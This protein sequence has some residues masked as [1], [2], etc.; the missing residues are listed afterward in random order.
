MRLR[1]HAA[2]GP[3]GRVC[4]ANRLLTAKGFASQGW[5]IGWVD[6]WGGREKAVSHRRCG[7]GSEGCDGK[8][9]VNR[10]THMSYSH[11][12]S[13]PIYTFVDWEKTRETYILSV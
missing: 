8:P 3:V 1:S 13:S 7:R 5:D 4:P 11:I 12:V 6:P 9:D 2:D 10:Q